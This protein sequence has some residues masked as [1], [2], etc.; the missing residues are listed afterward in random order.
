M[1][2]LDPA[3]LRRSLPPNIHATVDQVTANVD[4]AVD[5]LIRKFEQSASESLR[6]LEN[7]Q[8][9][10]ELQQAVDQVKADLEADLR[11][12]DE[13]I[14]NV[15]DRA[16]EAD[17]LASQLNTNTAQLRQKLAEVTKSASELEARL[18]EFRSKLGTFA[19]KS[20]GLIASAAVKAIT[21]GV[22]V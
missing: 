22:A 20:G 2:R 8:F 19:E 18:N 9:T 16:Q 17:A 5:E 11:R 6:R 1:I 4:Q 14:S 7:R 3:I 10:A 15:R 21:G 12:W 13:S